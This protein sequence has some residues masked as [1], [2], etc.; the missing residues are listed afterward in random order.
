MRGYPK[1]WSLC[2]IHLV[3][4]QKQGVIGWWTLYGVVCEDL[5]GWRWRGAVGRIRI[6]RSA[7]TYVGRISIP[8]SVY[9][10]E[11][12]RSRRSLGLGEVGRSRCFPILNEGVFK[13]P[14]E[15]FLTSFFFLYGVV[16]CFSIRCSIVVLAGV[17]GYRVWVWL[18]V[19]Y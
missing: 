5:R 9:L 7:E 19:A 12:S 18:N 14:S 11:A 6:P 2:V 17:N 4:R 16:L 15:Y 10:G 13:N 1:C 3:V 8:R